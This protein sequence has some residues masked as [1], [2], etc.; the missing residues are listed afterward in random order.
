MCIC[1]LVT[2]RFWRKYTNPVEEK[3]VQTIK[4]KARNFW[5][6]MLLKSKCTLK[7]KTTKNSRSGKWLWIN[8]ELASTFPPNVQRWSDWTSRSIYAFLFPMLVHVNMLCLLIFTAN[9]KSDLVN[10]ICLFLVFTSWIENFYKFYV[11]FSEDL[12]SYG[13]YACNGQSGLP[14]CRLHC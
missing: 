2:Y 5:R 11:L 7:Q 1:A 8:C 6:S 9:V 14:K 4:R 3:M 10:F 13:S 12:Y